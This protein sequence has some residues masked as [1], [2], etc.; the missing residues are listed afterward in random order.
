MI[1]LGPSFV[2]FVSLSLALYLS[3]VPRDAHAFAASASDLAFCR[4]G[5][6]PSPVQ[7]VDGGTGSTSA[8]LPLLAGNGSCAESSF[9][10]LGGSFADLGTGTVGVR[11]MISISNL[12]QTPTSHGSRN[13][14]ASFEE[15][16]TPL[17]TG[18]M[19]FDIALTGTVTGSARVSFL[20][21]ATDPDFST[22]DPRFEDGLRLGREDLPAAVSFDL[23][24]TAGE[25]FDVQ[26]TLL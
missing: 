24:V 17:A 4:D 19:H 18:L 23:P 2:T 12:P 21:F 10:S 5:S 25:S 6:G 22:L 15:T 1:L 14:G 7:R 8:S 26:M 13:V 9:S 16:I 3:M 20:F 11:S